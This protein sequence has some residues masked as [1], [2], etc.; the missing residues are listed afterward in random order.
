MKRIS[1]M[2]FLLCLLLSGCGREE[3]NA[4][5]YTFTDDLGREVTVHEPQRVATLLGSFAQIWQLSGGE[6]AA[7]VDDAW[8]DLGLEL[9]EK[10]VNLGGT[11]NPGLELLM[12]V[13]P[14][15][16]LA[17][18]KRRQNLE[19]QETLE[20]MGVAVAYFSVEDFEDY[21]R[22]LDICTDITGRKE[23]YAE[24]GIA[25]QAQIDE[26]RQQSR[27]RLAEHDAPTILCIAASASHVKA[28]N[29]EGNVLAAI[30]KDLGCVNIADSEH[31]LLEELSMEH[32]LFSDPDMIFF[33]P[34]GDNAEGM[35]RNVQQLLTDDPAWRELTAVKNGD[36]YFM[37][38]MLFNLKP[39]HRWGEAYAELEAVL[40]HE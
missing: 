30:A 23:L 3:T 4:E 17:S 12:S 19:W 35:Q 25:V 36:V 27:E 16:V 9:S 6:I 15:F 32:I 24:Y 5:G 28:K 2:A 38:K 22:V 31:M 37:D 21:L 39:N 10:T 1:M 14:D 29:S 20:A 8:E 11:E 26:V 33:V 13:Q 34:R 18:P 7:T 40:G